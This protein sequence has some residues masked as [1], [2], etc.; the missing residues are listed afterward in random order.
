VVAVGEALTRPKAAK[1]E[2]RAKVFIVAQNGFDS[3]E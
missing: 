2:R 3:E 1:A